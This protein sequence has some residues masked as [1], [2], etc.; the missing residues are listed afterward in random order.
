MNF[1]FFPEACEEGNRNSFKDPSNIVTFG[2][3]ICLEGGVCDVK[4]YWAALENCS[5]VLTAIIVGG[6]QNA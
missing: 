3:L 6:I 5:P 2:V 1:G 4:H